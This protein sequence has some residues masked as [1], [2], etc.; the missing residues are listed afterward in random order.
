MLTM[1]LNTVLLVVL[2][3]AV[4]AWVSKDALS[5]LLFAGRA[6]AGR[7]MRAAAAADPS[8]NLEQI[9][10]DAAAEIGKARDTLSEINGSYR[11]ATDSLQQ[12]T[13]EQ[14]KLTRQIAAKKAS[15][16]SED[17]LQKLARELLAVNRRVSSA[18]NSLALIEKN[19]DAIKAV[20][21]TNSRKIEDARASAKNLNQELKVSQ[22]VAAAAKYA[23]NVNIDSTN[24]TGAISEYEESMRAK[25]N[26][27]LGVADTAAMLDDGSSDNAESDND[28]AMLLDSIPAD[29]K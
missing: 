22:S 26:S 11:T 14:S 18:T 16:A 28:V 29:N 5:K 3:L 6:Q 12:Y 7:A 27:N 25:I 17:E 4:L 24:L 13:D 19:R 23:S 21:V 8:A 15:N 10:E 1:T 2:I 9:I 20:I